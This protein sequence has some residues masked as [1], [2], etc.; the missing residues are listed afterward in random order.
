MDVQ[1]LTGPRA[2]EEVMALIK[3]CRTMQVAVA[4]A[5]QNHIVDAMYQHRDKLGKLVIGTHLY[6]TD[7]A[8]LR[9]FKDLPAARC[10][11]PRG[12]LY[13]PKVY[14]FELESGWAAA[15]GSHNLT[16]GAFGHPGNVEA[17]LLLKAEG[18]HQVIRDLRSFVA[19]SWSAGEAID[20][21][22]FLF[23]YEAHYKANKAR[24]SEL[25]EP[26]HRFKRPLPA[27]TQPSPL[28]LTWEDFLRQVRDPRHHSLAGR[29]AVLGRAASLFEQRGSFA[30]MLVGERKAIAGT[31]APREV[32]FEGHDW[33]WFGSM[34]GSGTF[35]HLVRD[36]P[37]VLSA[38][39]D[40]IPPRGL[41]S[42]AQYEQ[43]RALFEQAFEEA[44]RAGGVPTASR[45]L[46]MKRP[47]TFICV[48]KRNI[49]ALCG[50]TGY[51][52]GQLSLSNYWDRIIRPIQAG[53]VWRHPRPE[54]REE[55]RIWDAR[56]AMLDSIYYDPDP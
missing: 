8:V 4:W 39:L 16:K 50:A 19:E 6:R 37:A 47:D 17:S 26:F 40:R 32:Q 38:A 2:A 9:L 14:L 29:L 43:F 11:E 18:H 42:Q 56:V 49:D 54:D 45:L 22:G 53:P 36:E 7:P 21:D 44:A 12:D 52:P 15:V 55:A 20:E 31:F 1:V 25:Q 48:S 5:G 35:K 33:A 24:E 27:A 13:H 23:S 46:A 34:F 28:T 51:P 10:M 3:V 30:E 41:V